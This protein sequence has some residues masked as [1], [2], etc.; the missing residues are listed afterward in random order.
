[1][2]ALRVA[3]RLAAIVL[4]MV[5]L[6]L[7]WN[8]GRPF[9]GARARAWRDRIYLYWARAT[10]HAMGMRRTRRG[11][12]P[13]GPGLLVSNHLGYVD[14]LLLAAETG[15]VFVSKAE[16]R[17]W[18]LVGHT[19]R[20][21]GTLFVTR[22]DKRVLAEVNAGIRAALREG[23]L[24]A[25]F[26]EGTTTDGERCLPFRPSLFEPAAGGAAPV[27][28]AALRYRT[29]DAALPAERV[30]AWTGGQPFLAHVRGLL[31]L[32]GFDAEARFGPLPLVG[33]DRKELAARAEALVRE[34]YAGLRT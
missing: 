28:C 33:G 4:V 6:Y 34:L 9:A 20:A 18:P 10:A 14:V 19:A 30:V 31:A 21:M 1:M 13:R 2:G 27:H 17:H 26:P 29:R 32:P 23:R 7:L 8:A 11:P 24:V 5:G 22:G 3:L 16:V 12:L 15:A 25:F